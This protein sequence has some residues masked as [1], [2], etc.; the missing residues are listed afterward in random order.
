MFED[1]TC[2]TPAVYQRL[3]YLCGGNASGRIE[4]FHLDTH[5]IAFGPSVQLPVEVI[6]QSVADSVTFVAGKQLVYLTANCTTCIDLTGGS[7]PAAEV[8]AH[9]KTEVRSAT[10]MTHL[11]GY[12]YWTV[13]S[14]VYRVMAGQPVKVETVG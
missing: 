13:G 8:V 7:N 5:A 12:V 1:R 3:A 10:N 4:T 14:K 6:G 9:E 2:F 11:H